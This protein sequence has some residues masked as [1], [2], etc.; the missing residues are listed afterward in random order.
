MLLRQPVTNLFECIDETFIWAKLA[1]ALAERGHEGMQKSFDQEACGATP[2]YWETM[3]EYYEWVA[4]NVGMTWDELKQKAPY[5]DMEPEQYWDAAYEDTY[6]GLSKDGSTYAG[7]ARCAAGDIKD[8]PLKCGPYGDTMIYI[9][10]HGAEQFDMPAASSEYLPMPYYKEPED[11]TDYADAYPLV[12]TEG[13]IPYFHHGTLRNNPYIR[14]IYPA[15]EVWISP[16]YASEHGIAD[17]DWVNVKSPRTDGLDVF[18]D[19]STGKELTAEGQSLVKDGIYGVAK[20][21]EGIAKDCAY[22]ERFWNPEFLEEGKDPRKSWTT[23][24]MN[25]LTKNTGY[26]N[27]E[28]GTYTLRGINVK[29]EKA[30]RPDGI[31]YEPADFAPWLPQPTENTGGGAA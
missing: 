20:V 27:P 30:A 7:F 21:T 17:G 11:Y 29:I 3:D 28:F 9:G 19:L 2:A 8:N 10:R 6:R 15:P 14:E 26:Y 13:R 4:S 5:N 16:E 22:M 18:S 1:K 24:N 31:W 12:L 25:V 23:C